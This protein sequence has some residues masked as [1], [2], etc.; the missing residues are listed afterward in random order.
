MLT[1]RKMQKEGGKRK[2]SFLQGR[3]NRPFLKDEV[4]RLLSP[5]YFLLMVVVGW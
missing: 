5:R 1:M 2:R 3:Y 4:L